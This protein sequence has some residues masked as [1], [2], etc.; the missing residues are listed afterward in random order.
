M[1]GSR[2]G[3]GSSGRHNSTLRKALLFILAILVLIPFLFPF[4]WMLLG[5]FKE[6]VDF[7][8]Y[9]PIWIFKPTIENYV[10]VFVENDFGTFAINSTIVAA[11]TTFFGLLFGIP[12]AYAVARYK[13][14]GFALIVLAARMAPGI[15]FLLPWFVLFVQLKLTNTYFALVTSHLIF[16]LPLILWMMIGFIEAV[17]REIEQAAMVDGCTVWGSLFRI[18]IPLTLPGVA[19]SGILCFIFS[20]NNFL[21]SVV[22]AGESTKT[23]PVAV[24]NFLGYQSI[25]W[26]PLSAAAS[27]I[28]LP[29]L[30]LA[31]IVQ[32]YIV[33]GLAAG[34]ISG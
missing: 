2:G 1:V 17:P 13:R 32:K 21:F 7:M 28:T 30:F 11:L 15:A 18:I 23:L 10:K 31:L 8:S 27:I 34:G 4:I 29:V 33:Q 6:E 5:S 26:G 14:T 22:L 20:W 16:T 19:A 9:P 25:A 24:F 12:G 3:A